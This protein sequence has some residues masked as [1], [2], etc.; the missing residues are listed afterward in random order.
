[1]SNLVNSFQLNFDDLFTQCLA[2][3]AI[4][5]GLQNVLLFD[6]SPETLR[7][8][9][10][11]IA[12]MLEVVT[13]NPVTK[14]TLS[15][16][17]TEE[18]LW[19]S[20]GISNESQESSFN[21]KPGLLAND[22]QLRLVIIPDLTKLSLAAVRACVVMMGASVAHLER[23]GQQTC[24][25]PNIYW[26]AGCASSEVG[27]VSPHLLDRFA[28]RLS[29]MIIK[30]QDRISEIL[31]LIDNETGV[32]QI[33]PLPN[34][35]KQTL[36]KALQHRPEITT[37][38]TARI[39]NYTSNLEVYSPRREIALARLSVAYARLQG[40][41]KMSEEHVDAAAR[42]IN[43]QP[44]TKRQKPKITS[45]SS[46]EPLETQNIN[47]SAP[48]TSNPKLQ[49]NTLKET[50]AVYES[51]EPETLSPTP[52]ITQN[53]IDPY[54]ED[55]A[56]V[57]REVAS[58]RLPSRHFQNKSIAR[59]VIIGVE[60]A[61]NLQDIAIVRTL[62][63]AAKFQPIRQAA[64]TNGK[65]ILSPTDLYSYRRA[66][67]AEQMLTLVLDH[68]CLQDYKWQDELLPYLSWAYVERASVCLV[69]VGAA[70]ARNELQ[71]EKIIA[72]SILVPSINAGIEA[73]AG[74]ATPL[75]HGLDLALQTLRHA[76]QHGR[77]MIKQAMLV[78]ITDGRGNIPL[79]A[80]RTNRIIPPVGRK[81]VEDALQVAERIRGLDGV[82][83]ILLNPQSRQYPEIPLELAKALGAKVVLI[84]EQE[85]WEL[86]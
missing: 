45:V 22:S 56:P 44:I 25:R 3:A 36:Q 39:L 86:E 84:P 65:L 60:K 58:L 46:L 20:L 48:Q 33:Q 24:W 79:E 26:L 66:P 78:V 6:T 43:L 64:W 16:F 70:N 32:L 52:I 53:L 80:S 59:G 47:S 71:A 29:G 72:Q 77:S 38:A 9:G 41:A 7:I 11:V 82:K 49:I 31:S 54:P 68:T 13:A 50:L 8:S 76:L 27:M 62:L 21:W 69:Q 1:M 67:V 75:A 23:H 17:E 63:E 81:G 61:T 15:T 2:C 28:L 55:N 14:V 83:A 40:V 5:P 4:T 19:G 57:E 74:I 51:D 73:E 18:D 37:Q 10:L 12:Q 30:P 35:I 85:T 42:M 34:E